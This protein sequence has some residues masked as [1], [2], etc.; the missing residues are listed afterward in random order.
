MC[1]LHC[2]EW[3]LAKT[4]LPIPCDGDIPSGIYIHDSEAVPC[5][6]CGKAFD[7]HKP[8]VCVL[9]VIHVELISVLIDAKCLPTHHPITHRHV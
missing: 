6:F 9:F 1:E 5:F 8:S 7:D 2:N 4:S 3:Q